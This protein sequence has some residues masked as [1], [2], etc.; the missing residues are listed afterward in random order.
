MPDPNCTLSDEDANDPE[1][2]IVDGFDGRN[3]AIHP[4]ILTPAIGVGGYKCKGCDD[5]SICFAMFAGQIHSEVRMSPDA[6]R[7]VAAT[8]MKAIAR[9]DP[10]G[11]N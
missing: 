9:A 4:A 11:A 7:E 1:W 6:A 8:L 5:G 10:K 2:I 3:V